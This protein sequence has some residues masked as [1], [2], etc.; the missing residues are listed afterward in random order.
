MSNA[1]FQIKFQVYSAPAYFAFTTC[2][3]KNKGIEMLEAALQEVEKSIL[4]KKGRFKITSK[5]LVKLSANSSPKF[6]E[7]RKKNSSKRC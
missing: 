7:K 6:R 4:E 2:Y 1:D 5:V 3:D